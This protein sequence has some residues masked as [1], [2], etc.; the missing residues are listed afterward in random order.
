[1]WFKNLRIYRVTQKIDLS[2]E[3]LEAELLNQAF[4]PCSSLDFSRY[5]WVPP[6]GQHSEMLTHSCDGNIM[7]CARKQEKILPA[8]AINELVDEKAMELESQNARK[9]FRKERLNL[10]DDAIHT[11]LPRALTKSSLTFAY[12]SPK[13]KMLIIDAASVNKAEEFLDHL[14]ATLVTLPVL[15]LSCTG[16]VSEIMTRWIKQHPAKGF[17]L[18]DECELQSARESK[19]T[20]RCKN[21]EL[22]SDEIMNH[23]KAGKRVIQLAI[24][25]KDAIRFMLSEDFSIKRI[26][27]DDIVQEQAQGDADDFATQFDQDFSIMALQINQFLEELLEAFGGVDAH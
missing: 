6:L 23:I 22:E 8:A 13:T 1:M 10:K 21:Q 7:I 18:D 16:D 4:K 26:R 12:F 2:A 20:I 19:N 14:R 27:F 24:N 11:L 5:G 3:R 17:E 25:W 9:I 15:P